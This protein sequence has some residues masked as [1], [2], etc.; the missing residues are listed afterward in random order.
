MYD[1]FM[2]FLSMEPIAP[3]PLPFWMR[4]ARHEF[5]IAARS[6]KEPLT[7]LLSSEALLGLGYVDDLI[8]EAQLRLLRDVVIVNQQG[9]KPQAAMQD[10]GFCAVRRKKVSVFGACQP[11]G[12]LR[13]T[14]T[15]RQRFPW[16]TRATPEMRT[17]NASGGSAFLGNLWGGSRRLEG[18]VGKASRAGRGH[19]SRR[20]LFNG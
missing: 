8:P 18:I 2:H 10:V 16:T 15:T 7:A 5:K 13:V 20:A 3:N 9:D 19:R 14:S 12:A 4:R 17:S 11:R 6:T 1:Q